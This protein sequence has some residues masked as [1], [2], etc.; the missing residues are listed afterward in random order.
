MLNPYRHRARQSPL[1]VLFFSLCCALGVICFLQ[2]RQINV[3]QSQLD[4]AAAASLAS[5]SKLAGNVKALRV[6]QAAHIAS[7]S[8]LSAELNTRTA[9][10]HAKAVKLQKAQAD[11]RQCHENSKVVANS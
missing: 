2:R 3:M 8:R 10:L 6:L 1:Q 7:H 9:A 4:T 5:R 11:A